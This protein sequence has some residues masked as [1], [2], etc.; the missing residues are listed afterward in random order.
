ME[1]LYCNL[2][3]GEWRK[4]AEMFDLRIVTL[5]D[6]EVAK[7]RLRERHVATGVAKDD[8]EAVWRGESRY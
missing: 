3:E 5:L 6:K 1:G 7:N 2:D 8:E 4:A